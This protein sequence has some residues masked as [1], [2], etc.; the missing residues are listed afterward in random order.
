MS[1]NKMEGTARDIGGKIESAVGNVTGDTK[2]Q[3]QGK[4]DQVAGQAQKAYGN[5]KDAVSDAADQ[6][7]SKLSDAA[8]KVSEQASSIGGQV[9]EAGE[10][11]A[12]TVADYV[13]NEPVAVML[14]VAAVGMLIGYLI[15]RP[16]SERAIELGRFRAAYRDR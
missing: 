7:G 15:G 13:R 2:N 8:S 5:A 4:V 12:E 9:Y 6:A 14:G 1:E 10:Y 11:A 16:A 3:A